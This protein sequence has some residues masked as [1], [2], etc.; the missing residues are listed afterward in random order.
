MA[1]K[2]ENVLIFVR[3]DEDVGDTWFVGLFVFWLVYSFQLDS[4]RSG[5]RSYKKLIIKHFIGFHK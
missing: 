2:I 4:N 3:V 1:I 5:L